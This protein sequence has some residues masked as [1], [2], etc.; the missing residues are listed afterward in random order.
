MHCFNTAELTQPCNPL[1]AIKW[2]S[3][4]GVGGGGVAIPQAC[5]G[6]CD[7]H[8]WW[9]MVASEPTILVRSPDVGGIVRRPS[10]S[11]R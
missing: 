7:P 6:W 11:I 2:S 5:R 9:R 1:F 3:L 4:G 10:D 8:M